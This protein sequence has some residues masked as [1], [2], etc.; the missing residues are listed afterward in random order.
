MLPDLSYSIM[1]PVSGLRYITGYTKSIH[2]VNCRSVPYTVAIVVLVIQVSRRAVYPDLRYSIMV[3]VSGYRNVAGYTEVIHSVDR[4]SIPHAVSIVIQIELVG[5]SWNT[6][7]PVVL[8]GAIAGVNRSIQID[9]TSQHLP[10]QPA[11]PSC[12][13]NR[14][15]YYR[16]SMPRLLRFHPHP[17][18]KL[19]SEED[20]SRLYYETFR[21]LRHLLHFSRFRIEKMT[22]ISPIIIFHT[23]ARSRKIGRW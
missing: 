16:D 14:P 21:V 15:I 3:P 17:S 18:R 12:C 19:L 6:P 2:P 1:V 10:R 4:C 23:P 11:E 5:E 13:M 20:T 8:S 7:I 9:P 22:W